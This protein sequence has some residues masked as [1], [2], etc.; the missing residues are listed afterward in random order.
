MVEVQQDGSL[1]LKAEGA[2]IHGYRLHLVLKPIPTIIFW[3]DPIESIEWPRGGE[4][5]GEIFGRGDLF[6]PGQR[7]G[8]R[9]RRGGGGQTS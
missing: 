1:L 2:R 7:L 8:G 6:M 4:Q 9:P 5:E 3:I